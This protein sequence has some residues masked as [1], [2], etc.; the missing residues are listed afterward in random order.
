METK[1]VL[2]PC[3]K[4]N[5]PPPPRP[6]LLLTSSGCI[7]RVTQFK[8]FGVFIDS[9]LSWNQW[10]IQGG[11]WGDASPTPAYNGIFCGITCDGAPTGLQYP[12]NLL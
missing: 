4:L 9:T 5:K 7:E 12:T 11:G 6:N 8:L 10:R 2:E 1:L 3:S